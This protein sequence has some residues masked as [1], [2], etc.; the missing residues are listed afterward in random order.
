MLEAGNAVAPQDG[1]AVDANKFRRVQPVFETC[2]GLEQQI[3][4]IAD[5]EANVI[6]LRID[7]IDLR[8]FDADEFGA[9]GNPQFVEPFAFAAR[10]LIPA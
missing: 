8:R 1:G 9:V 3:R 5:M 10:A 2:D 7:A 4:P 6:A